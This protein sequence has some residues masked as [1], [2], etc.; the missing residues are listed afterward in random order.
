MDITVAARE[1]S[2][3][4]RLI[5]KIYARVLLVGFA[6]TPACLI[7]YLFFFQDPALKFENHP[8]HEIAIATATLE[9]LF[10]TYVTWR[11]YCSSGE[12]LLRWMTLGFLGFVLIYALHGALTGMAHHN[13][14]LFL[15]Y[16]PASRLV[17]AVLLLVGLLSYNRPPDS[18]GKRSDSR[19][20][21]V[22]T[23]LFVCVNLAV[24]WVAYSPVAGSLAVRV[25]MEGGAM[26][27]SALN[28][29]MLMLRRIRTPLMVIFGIAVTSF[30]GTV[31]VGASQFGRDGKTL[32]PACGR[33]AALL[34]ET[35]GAQSRCCCVSTSAE[36][37]GCVAGAARGTLSS[38]GAAIRTNRRIRHVPA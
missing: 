29:A 4:I 34:R 32:D 2:A 27:L 9:G 22:W 16:G 1:P 25:S 19:G 20:W 3:G 33:H 10:V 31:S 23:A 35:S 28:V 18:V 5:T 37:L 36:Y 21:L 12:P 38:C 30:E 24:A 15:L 6:L 8:V 11:C 13:I 26:I 17:M 7:A 14:W